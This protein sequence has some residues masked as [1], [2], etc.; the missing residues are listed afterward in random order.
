MKKAKILI[1][2]D[3]FVHRGLI[4]EALQSFDVEILTVINPVDERNPHIELEWVL[5][6]IE[7]HLPDLMILDMAWTANDAKILDGMLKASDV[8][9]FWHSLKRDNRIPQVFQLLDLVEQSSPI[10]TLILTDYAAQVQTVFNEVITVRADRKILKKPGIASAAQYEK[11]LRPEVSKYLNAISFLQKSESEFIP[12]STLT[13]DLLNMAMEVA[14][15]TA[16]ILITGET[17][18][19]KTHLAKAIHSL[20]PR[21]AH[22]FVERN[23]ASIPHE[24]FYSTLFGHEKGAFTGA[25]KY[26]PGILEKA[27]GGTV[28]LDEIGDLP[29]EEQIF[30]LKAIEEHHVYPLGGEDNDGV[31]VDVRFILATNKD[32][33]QQVRS[34][35]FREDLYYRINVVQLRL[36][37]L[38]QRKNDIPL[39]IESF[40]KKYAQEMTRSLQKISDHD[41]AKILK[42]EFP[43]NI[44]QLRT[45]IQRSFI[46]RISILDS[47]KMEK[48]LR[49]FDAAEKKGHGD[50]LLD[51]IVA[52]KRT[53]S[54]L[55]EET[56]NEL[57]K[58]VIEITGGNKEAAALLG[59]ALSTFE[60]KK[61]KVL[62]PKGYE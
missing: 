30:L 52:G 16:P 8:F 53:L 39:L 14:G 37:P 47:L 50:T 3:M 44:R 5:K 10:L 58:K 43:G 24:L 54:E 25:V 45:I 29:E 1:V 35:K 60:V 7:R 32:L 18:I 6:S 36:P 40:S 17:G 46:L 27:N 31:E 49:P 22:P 9:Q 4:V 19:G 56:E 38:R 59:L 23:V 20:S 13:I 26:K 33:E 34:G 48:D 21:S 12:K 28:F 42:Y 2:E 62:N 41:M 51:Q 61:R 57:I 15:T 11:V 55:M